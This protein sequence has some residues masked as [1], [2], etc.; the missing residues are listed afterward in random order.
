MTRVEN[1]FIVF[2]G[3]DGSGKGT[4]ID[5]LKKYYKSINNKDVVFT[6]EPT[7]LSPWAKK[8][9]EI[10][11]S[12]QNIKIKDLQLLFIL[13]RK[14]HIEN[15]ITPALKKNKIV[16]SDRY[17]LSSLVYGSYNGELCWKTLFNYHKKI[18]KD[19]F[20]MPKVTIF[21]DISIDVAFSR[22]IN[23]GVDK[24]Y[25]ETKHRL[26]KIRDSYINIGK[27]FDGFEIIDGAGMS[28]EVFEETRIILDKYL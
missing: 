6:F 7:K 2:E 12:N 18:L 1:N 17:F 16:Y 25:F 24:S 27:H 28:E 23:R 20:V 22:I 15:L 14:Y 5:L 9:D 11:H 13:D 8:I 21:L 19:I 3:I 10:L 4:Q 26:K